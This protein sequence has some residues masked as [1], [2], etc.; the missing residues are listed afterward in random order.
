MKKF[1]IGKFSAIISYRLTLSEDF[2]R[3]IRNM[4]LR[5]FDWKKFSDGGTF[6]GKTVKNELS[7]GKTLNTKSWSRRLVVEIFF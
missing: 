6:D 5:G 3:V 1:L 4:R 7:L 2:E